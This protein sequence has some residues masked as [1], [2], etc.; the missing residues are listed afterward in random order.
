MARAGGEGLP[1]HRPVVKS[2]AGRL[3][4]GHPRD[5]GTIRRECGTL[6]DGP[7]GGGHLKVSQRKFG[8]VSSR[9]KNLAV[10][11]DSVTQENEQEA[12]GRGGHQGLAALRAPASSSCGQLSSLQT[13]TPQ[14]DST[15]PPVPYFCGFL[16]HQT[17]PPSREETESFCGRVCSRDLFTAHAPHPCPGRWSKLLT[18]Q[19]PNPLRWPFWRGGHSAEG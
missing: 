6:E 12:H 14:D 1:T 17:G 11:E 13:P 2:E 15:C 3:Q 19:S 4:W 5:S 8:G 18:L 16:C 10:T 9:A 7:W